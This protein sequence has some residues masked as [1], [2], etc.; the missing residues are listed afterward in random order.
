MRV[1]HALFI[2]VLVYGCSASLR[3]TQDENLIPYL[4]NGLYGFMTPEGVSVIEPRFL[5]A[6]AFSEGL[7]AVRER[8]NYGFID[9][10]GVFKIQPQYDFAYS[11]E[12]GKAKVYEDGK[13]LLINTRGDEILRCDCKEMESF[14]NG[15]ARI[16]T[17]S[18]KVG[19][20]DEMGNFILDTIFSKIGAIQDSRAIVYG[21]NHEFYTKQY[22]SEDSQNE[23]G[24]IDLHGN[25]VIPYH[26]FD[27]VLQIG[28]QSFLVNLHDGRSAIFHY[29][30]QLTVLETNLR[31]E[32]I[33]T[34]FNDGLAGVSLYQTWRHSAKA[35]EDYDSHYSYGG[36]I[37]KEGEIVISDTTIEAV[38]PF[39]KG[40][41]FVRHKDDKVSIID[42]DG[43]YKASQ[44]FHDFH[45]DGFENGLAFVK[46]RGRWGAIDRD[47]NFVIEAKYDDIIYIDWE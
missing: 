39:E 1:V 8:G 27:D 40:L 24:V 45:K 41:A 15:V 33:E 42:R 14:K 35:W 34:S 37:N 29:D 10:K 2:V 16:E 23:V 9:V 3:T 31:F 4:D 26:K 20:I 38:Y 12:N 44:L 28:E 43:N 21:L 22:S 7:A 17:E 46:C 32:E 6:Y 5:S 11:F 19:L 47:L 30:G 25:F 13:V 36:Y 18:K